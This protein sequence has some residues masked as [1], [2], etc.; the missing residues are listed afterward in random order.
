[1]IKS[2]IMS[3]MAALINFCVKNDN[4]ELWP[5]G[6]TGADYLQGLTRRDANGEPVGSYISEVD[7]V[8]DVETLFDQIS[9]WEEF[10]PEDAREGCRYFK[11]YIPEGWT[12][13]RGAI[14]LAEAQAAECAVEIREGLHGRELV[15]KAG[16]PVKANNI[17]VILEGDMLATWH[18]GP[19]LAPLPKDASSLKGLDPNTAV[20]LI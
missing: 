14:S 7:T 4:D 12:G 15:S 10:S 5:G 1:M 11:A 19:P 9:L 3:A 8:A 20:K 13:Y 6:P 16:E 18:P 17:T 2:I